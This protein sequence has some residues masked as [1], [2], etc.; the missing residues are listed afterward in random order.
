[1]EK[2][3]RISTSDNP[4][5]VNVPLRVEVSYQRVSESVRILQ[6]FARGGSAPAVIVCRNC[7][8]SIMNAAAS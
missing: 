8:V 4:A 1:M 7:K 2:A 3:Q 6:Q 5:T